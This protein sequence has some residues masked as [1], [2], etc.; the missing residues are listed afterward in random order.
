MHKRAEMVE[1]DSKHIPLS[2]FSNIFETSHT[3][4]Y[5]SLENHRFL[6]SVT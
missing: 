4:P 3:K 1:F 2:I 5:L 6:K